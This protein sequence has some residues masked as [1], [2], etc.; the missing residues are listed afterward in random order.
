MLIVTIPHYWI[1]GTQCFGWNLVGFFAEG[2]PQTFSLKILCTRKNLSFGILTEALDFKLL[3]IKQWGANTAQEIWREAYLS[4]STLHETMG[5]AA[6]INLHDGR[7]SVDF[8]R[9]ALLVFSG[10]TALKVTRPL[11][12]T[13]NVPNKRT[14]PKGN[15]EW[16]VWSSVILHEWISSSISRQPGGPEKQFDETLTNEVTGRTESL[17]WDSTICYVLGHWDSKV[18]TPSQNAVSS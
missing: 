8:T 5:G 15:M 7:C 1:N 17:A 2:K 6:L 14:C 4:L 3:P 12:R 9:F 18:W 11:K 10:G 13:N 16:L